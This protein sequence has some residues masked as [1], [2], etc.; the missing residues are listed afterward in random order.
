MSKRIE[1]FAH[2]IVLGD[3]GALTELAVHMIHEG[4]PHAKAFARA[5]TRPGHTLRIGNQNAHDAP[6]DLGAPPS[7][8]D[9]GAEYEAFP[10]GP[11]VYAKVTYDPKST[12]PPQ[13]A[14]YA[15]DRPTMTHLNDIEKDAP[16]LAGKAQ[17]ERERQ[18]EEVR[19][20]EGLRELYT[21]AVRRILT[22]TRPW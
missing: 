12:S 17:D 8:F 21:P 9:Y 1:H 20:R 14:K 3:R 5:L 10:I 15:H 18:F 4:H 13:L 2:R 7:N 22:R 11:H 19:N 6:P 16:E